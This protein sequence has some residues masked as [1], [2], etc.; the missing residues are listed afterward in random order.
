V[1]LIAAQA[2]RSAFVAAEGERRA[3]AA[4]ALWPSH[5]LPQVT[6]ALA[7]IGAAARQGKPPSP[8]ALE[9]IRSAGRAS[10]LAVEPLLVA[11]TERLA[12]G[13]RAAAVRF[14]KAALNREPRSS[15]AHFLL[16]DLYVREQRIGDALGHV[17]VLGRRIGGGG[18]EPFAA[19]LAIYLRDPAKVA[20]V[21]PVLLNNPALR[22]SVMTDLAKDAS[23]AATLRLLT[24]RGDAGEDW[25]RIAFERHLAGGSAGEARALLA[26]AGIVGGGTALSPWGVGKDVGPLAWQLLASA[27]GAAEAVPGGPLR[28][29]Y[30]GR[31]DASL[32][33]HLLLLPA[34]RYRLQAQFAGAV[35]PATLEWRV[36]CLAGARPLAAWPVKAGASAHLIEIPPGCSAQRLSLWGR[37]G[38]FPRT[39]ATELQRVSLDSLS[40]PR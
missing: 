16:A 8:E 13:D 18:A 20:E 12:A 25:F 14:L 1:L 17:A 4:L 2:A 6:L 35:P 31:G 28:L 5:P 24:R 15:A 32:A 40:A 27:D 38:D 29:V 7:S 22:N 19:A 37:M 26:S 21:R 33:E 3:A 39:T 10:P 30:Y 11:G 36:T 34:G 9:Q 23:A